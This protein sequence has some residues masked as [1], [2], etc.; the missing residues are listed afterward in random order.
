MA[1]LVL[2]GLAYSGA[3]RFIHY[4]PV[5]VVE[6][7]TSASPP[8][9]RCNRSRR[10]RGERPR[11]PWSCSPPARS[12][13]GSALRRGPAPRS[14]RSSSRSCGCCAAAR[15]CPGPGRRRRRL[16]RELRVRPR[17]QHDRRH[18][19]RPARA[20]PPGHPVEL[21][22]R[23]PP[24]SRRRGRPGSP[25]ESPV[26]HRVR[27]DARRRASRPRPRAVRSGLGQPRRP[28]L[29]WGPGDGRDRSYGCQRQVGRE[30][31]AGRPHP[32]GGPARRCS[33]PPPWSAGSRSPRWPRPHRDGSAH[34]AGVEPVGA[35]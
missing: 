4:V 35:C 6:G 19:R 28:A 22:R 15:P 18:P 24:P 10:A 20:Q 14:P 12:A 3:G 5:P 17:R 13:R 33:S 2:I 25:R 16:A 9:S 1:A 27:L 34:G 8:S 7:F 26:G 21:P 23:P 31:A 30:V 11:R 29:R 32:C